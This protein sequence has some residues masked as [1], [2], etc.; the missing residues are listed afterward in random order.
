MAWFFSPPTYDESVRVQGSMTYRQPT[1]YTVLKNGSSYTTKLSVTT[2]DFD[3]ADFV[4]QGGYTYP[5]TA[6]EAALLQAA[7]YQPFEE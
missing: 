1:G 4:Y 6:D 2:T 5:I 7:G 3:T